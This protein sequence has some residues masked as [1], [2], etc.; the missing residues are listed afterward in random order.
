VQDL[1]DLAK[2][3]HLNY[4][5]PGVGTPPHLAAEMFKRETGIDITHIPYRGGGQSAAALMGGIIDFEIEGLSVVMP[6]VKSGRL[7]AIAITG[8]S[9]DATCP[10]V[11]TMREQGV[12]DFEYVGW[13]GIAVPAATPSA[14]VQTIHDAI[15]R[16]LASK[17]ARDWFGAAAADA[18]PDTTEAFAAIIRS[19]YDKFGK[20]IRDA[21][22]KGD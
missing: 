19:D 1:L 12:R 18:T 20:I 11:P 14:V 10:D 8:T 7:R 13:V 3:R 4:G 22:I 16:V 15:A 6:H 5:S 21:G 2:T 9:R 17:E